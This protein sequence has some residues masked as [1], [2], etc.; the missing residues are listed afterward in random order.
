MA[1]K[2]RDGVHKPEQCDA[3]IDLLMMNWGK[4]EQ[5]NIEL[6]NKCV[7]LRIRK[8]RLILDM[9]QTEFANLINVTFQQIQKYEDGRNAISNIKLLMLC[10]KTHTD[11]NYFFTFLTGKSITINKEDNYAEER[12]QN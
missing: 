10:E 5:E 1:Y 8:R 9:T 7:G 4:S 2:R 6:F 3:K 11:I 12:P